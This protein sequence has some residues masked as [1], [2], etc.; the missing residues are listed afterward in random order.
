MTRLRLSCVT[1]VRLSRRAVELV[2]D[3]SGMSAIMRGNV[4]E[5]ACRDLDAITQHVAVAP[6]RFE[7][8]GRVLMGLPPGSPL[9]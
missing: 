9:V 8:T 5:R 4:L 7:P 1:A 2:R 6:S 3:F